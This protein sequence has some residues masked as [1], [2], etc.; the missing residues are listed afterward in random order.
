MAT[1]SPPSPLGSPAT[2]FA[3][4]RAAL[5]PGTGESA[6]ADRL[7][8][9]GT[10]AYCARGEEL[11]PDHAEDRLVWIASGSAKLCAPAPASVFP[12][13]GQL[14]AFHFAGDLFSVL[15]R[16]GRSGS[17]T[18]QCKACGN[19]DALR[20]SGVTM[21]QF[22]PQQSMGARR[23]DRHG[24]QPFSRAPRRSACAADRLRLPRPMPSHPARGNTTTHARKHKRA[25]ACTPGA[26][27]QFVGFLQ[28]LAGLSCP[29]R[30]SPWPTRPTMHRPRPGA[31]P[32]G[33]PWDRPWRA[34]QVLRR[35]AR[36]PRGSRP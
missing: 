1:I 9:I 34:A 24:A 30:A 16:S 3:G 23:C 5:P 11:A 28:G 19:E 7:C 14:L 32:G 2:C 26:R 31:W 33:P 10:P 22:P 4:F 17:G 29:R 18:G 13:S 15:R 35:S 12:P 27:P 20:R 25:N 6:V 36:A 8:A 21:R